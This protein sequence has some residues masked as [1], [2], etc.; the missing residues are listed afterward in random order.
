MVKFNK[1]IEKC[2]LY[3]IPIVGGGILG[4]DLMGH[5]EVE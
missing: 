5:L 3:D 1:F 2:Q 4:T